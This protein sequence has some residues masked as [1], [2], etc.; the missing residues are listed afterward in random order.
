MVKLLKVKK[1]NA[2]GVRGKSKVLIR[3]SRALREERP[4]FGGFLVGVCEK[5]NKFKK[6]T[7]RAKG[8][9]MTSVGCGGAYISPHKSQFRRESQVEM[10]K[11][12]KGGNNGRRSNRSFD[13]G[14]GIKKIK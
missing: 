7:N 13:G 3:K 1:K 14:G 4:C 8:R 11:E 12:I 10:K 6:T 5:G 9:P 2:G